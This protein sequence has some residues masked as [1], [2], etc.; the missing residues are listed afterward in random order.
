MLE[1]LTYERRLELLP[2]IYFIGAGYFPSIEAFALGV[3]PPTQRYLRNIFDAETLDA[4]TAQI[5]HPSKWILVFFICTT[6]EGRM[7]ITKEDT[8]WFLEYR[9]RY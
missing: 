1:Q 2:L 5:V 7:Q 4:E 9:S 8:L 6:Y 3:E